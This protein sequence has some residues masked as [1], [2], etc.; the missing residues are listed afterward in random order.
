MR[1]SGGNG[2]RDL[3]AG[4]LAI[5]LVVGTAFVSQFIGSDMRALFGMSGAAFFVAGFF[6]GGAAGGSAWRRGLIVSVPGLL[7]DAALIVNNG[8]R[9]LDLPIAITLTSVVCAIVGVAIR[10]LFT[11]ARGRA[12][13]LA[14]FFTLAL[15]SWVGIGLPRMLASTA[16]Q[17]GRRPAPTVRF[18]SLDGAE[19]RIP[20][21]GGRVA[22]L[23]FWATW[24]MP[25]RWELP[26]I[27]R[28]H[29]RFAADTRVALWAVDV[30]WGD[31]SPRRAASALARMGLA[32]PAAFDSGSAA[33]ALGVEALPAVVVVDGR[34]RL[35][36]SHTGYDRSEDLAGR[37]SAAVTRVLEES[38]S[39]SASRKVL[40]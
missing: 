22:V 24:C 33:Q 9:R 15:A 36:L 32:I 30:A 37:L 8:L 27:A 23:A 13:G 16:F 19:V 21:P 12:V 26:E 28:V 7:G 6:R 25:C 2:T 39:L 10:R 35:R 31:E 5:V 34:G 38:G 17:W 29:E 4:L 18:T 40:R 20:D 14:A 3:V 1:D 11:G